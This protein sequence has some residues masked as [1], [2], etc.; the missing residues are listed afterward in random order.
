MTEPHGPGDAKNES[1]EDEGM[2]KKILPSFGLFFLPLVCLGVLFA[3]FADCSGTAVPYNEFQAWVAIVAYLC[4]G[5]RIATLNKDEVKRYSGALIATGT[6][7]PVTLV[8]TTVV[9]YC[10]GFVDL[11]WCSFEGKCALFLGS[12]I[13]IWGWFVTAF[14]CRRFC[15]FENAIH[16]SYGEFNQRFCQL[17]SALKVLCPDVPCDS[18]NNAESN[19]P[20]VAVACK[21]IRCH[22]EEIKKEL[23]K[24][25]IPWVLATG[26]INVWG[27]LYSAEEALIEVLPQE[28]VIAGAIHDELRLEGSE[29]TQRDE[30]LAKLRQAVCIIDPGSRQFLKSSVSPVLLIITTPSQLPVHPLKSDYCYL[31]QAVGGT[32]PYKWNVTDNGEA[33]RLKDG[34]LSLDETTGIL[35]GKTPDKNYDFAFQVTVTDSNGLSLKKFFSLAIRDTVAAAP[36]PLLNAMLNPEARAVLRTIRGSINEYR[37]GLWNGLILARNRLMATLFLTSLTVYILLVIALIANAQKESILA[38]STFYVVGAAIGLGS[39]LRG[40]SENKSGVYDYGLSAAGLVTLPIFSGLTAIGGVLLMAML[41]Y[42][43]QILGPLHS[44]PLTMVT[45]PQ[46]R[47]GNVATSYFEQLT[48]SGGTEPY[49]WTLKTNDK[50]AIPDALE[51]SDA[52]VI[53][54]TPTNNGSGRFTVQLTDSTGS[55]VEKMFSLTIKQLPEKISNKPTVDTT[56]PLPAGTVGKNYS[57]RLQAVGGKPP[58]KWEVCKE[59][60]K[61]SGLKINE[62][63]G[64]LSGTPYEDKTFTFNALVKDTNNK[65]DN[66]SLSLFIKRPG[67]SLNPSTAAGSGAGGIIPPL[68][69]IFNLH[70]NLGGILLAAIFGLTPGLLFDKLKQLT[71]KRKEDL[72]NSQAPQAKPQA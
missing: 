7:L 5:F 63:T 36:P 59:Q 17:K 43:G 11:K 24:S 40:E 8:I 14:I 48:A 6:L 64:E 27:R 18:N 47:E 50:D 4:V 35:R 15:D 52:G 31:L 71:D 61:G 49:K 19:N 57:K 56:S 23:K 65:T 38:A 70:K 62:N 72:K 2:F 28:K 45:A 16:S 32:P 39:R 20:T 34:G 21:E 46:L 54:G 68:K 67:E 30:L 29:I 25:G 66:K 37:E 12:T 42:A 60:L 26:Y 41:P 9:I 3:V 22:T 69:D 53:S 33:Q 10:L 58:Y 51:L 1:S 13:S 55:M 44:T